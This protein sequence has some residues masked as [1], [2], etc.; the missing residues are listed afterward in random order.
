MA[1][2]K[3]GTISVTNGSAVITGSGTDWNNVLY[4]IKAN[5]SVFIAGDTVDYRVLTVDSATQITLTG[6]VQRSTGSGLIYAVSKDFTPNINL[7]LVGTGDIRTDQLFSR[8]M[9]N[10]DSTIGGGTF[11]PT[12]DNLTVTGSA[13][14]ASADIN[15]GAIDGTVIGA[16]T[17]AAGTFT[18]ITV[19]TTT[20][21]TDAANNRVGI[22]TASPDAA[23]HVV[24][25]GLIG[26]DAS[27]TRKTYTS[28][29]NLQVNSST[30][31][32]GILIDTPSTAGGYITFGNGAIAGRIV[33]EHASDH[34]AFQTGASERAR[35][36]SSGN[37]GIGTTSPDDKLHVAGSIRLESASNNGYVF[38]EEGTGGTGIAALYNGTGNRLDF[39]GG[40]GNNPTAFA[41]SIMSMERDSGNVG[42]GTTSP[43]ATLHVLTASSSTGATPSA[44]ADDLVV[45]RNGFSGVS[46]LSGTTSQGSIFFGDSGSSTIGRIVYNHSANDL[47]FFTN[48]TKRVTIDSS[49]NV[50]L[51]T[52]AP[53]N[54]IHASGTANLVAKFENTT[55]SGNAR[56][57]FK[58]PSYE[59]NIGVNNSGGAF[60]LYDG[61]N[62][63]VQVLA[64]APANS[65]YVNSSGNVGIGTTAPQRPLHITSNEPAIILEETDQV[66]D[67]TRSRIYASG[68]D[69]VLGTINDLVN[70]GQTGYAMVRGTGI[71]IDHH[72]FLT[73]GVERLRINSSGNVG[74]GTT[75]PTYGLHVRDATARVAVHADSPTNPLLIEQNSSGDGSVLLSSAGTLSLGVTNDSASDRVELITRNV[76]RAVIDDAGNVGIGTTSP[77]EK[78]HVVGNTRLHGS[79]LFDTFREIKQA[80]STAQGVALTGGTSNTTGASISLYGSTNSAQAGNLYL[81]SGGAASTGSIIFRNYNGSSFNT[82]MTIKD[83]GN[84]GIGTTSPSQRLHVAG[85]AE[86]EATTTGAP[87]LFLTNE[88]SGELARIFASNS[89][90]F[91]LQSGG[92]G[93]IVFQSTTNSEIARLKGS[94]GNVGIGTASANRRLTVRSSAANTTVLAVQ[95]NDNTSEMFT[96]TE[97]SSKHGRLNLRN[98]TN[99]TNVEIH[100]SGSSYFNGGNVGI[101]T[102][103]PSDK[104]HVTGGNVRFGGFD[105]IGASGTADGVHFTFD[106][107][108]ASSRSGNPGLYLRR[109][110]SDG[111]IAIFRRDTTTVGSI[112][113]TTTATSYNTSS[114]ERLKRDIASAGDAL[115]FLRAIP[116][117]E[118]NWKADG[119]HMP[120]GYVAQKL[121]PHAPY[122]VTAGDASDAMWSVDHSKLV[123]ALHRAIQQLEERVRELEAT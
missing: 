111:T 22:G 91:Y 109:R 11:S 92:S 81:S 70:S 90:T 123:P 30:G 39:V 4:N 78:L 86:I 36:A 27:A 12:F 15:G 85:N 72:R 52:T 62:N 5:D 23:L 43:A 93:D 24:G 56:A 1:Q 87:Y 9:N 106:G 71:A 16:T 37:F 50:G 76:T 103:S 68:G 17:A 75:L 34:M 32:A 101:G 108:I 110:T 104:L 13:S 118:F 35:I 67:E 20:L 44:S 55:A 6:A 19:D 29:G 54:K 97:T 122:A 47:S 96:I 45:E 117:D 25:N 46:I 21:V 99:A 116:V 57:I 84:V 63:I 113:V 48:N 8:A 60:T 66:A 18:T 7:P 3:V 59:W 107:A 120:F 65:L 112:S 69:F 83:S 88:T 98:A 79:V 10:L 33:Y 64:G 51:G 28:T 49:G 14:I 102:T 114:D 121:R 53:D 80:S 95:N 119:S 38:W 58:T 89:S 31:N 115:A 26:V 40:T 100:S 73:G 61:T 2:Y 41:T 94:T 82:H 74:I 105:G 77:S 42:I